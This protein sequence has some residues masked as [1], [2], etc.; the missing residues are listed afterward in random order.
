VELTFERFLSELKKQPPMSLATFFFQAE[1]HLIKQLKDYLEI[2]QAIQKSFFS[3]IEAAKKT[4]NADTDHRFWEAL[5]AFN[6]V[7]F[8]PRHNNAQPWLR[9]VNTIESL[10]GYNGSQLFSGQKLALKRQ[11]RLYFAYL[12]TWEHLRYI[13]GNEDDLNPSSEMLHLFSHVHTHDDDDCDDESCSGH[14]H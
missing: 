9:Y 12:L 14:S 6:K 5:I 4:S 10:Q 11:Y 1:V 7:S 2:D 13:A 3:L 8:N